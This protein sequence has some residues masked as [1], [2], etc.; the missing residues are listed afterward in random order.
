MPVKV[1]ARRKNEKG[2]P[3]KI[4]EEST[5]RVVGESETKQDAEIS[6]SY[7]NKAYKRKGK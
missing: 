1:R 4:V 5:D 6:A 3:W 7:R 2:K